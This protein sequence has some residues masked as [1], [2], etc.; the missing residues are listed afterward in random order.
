MLRQWQQRLADGPG[1]R[2]PRHQGAPRRATRTCCTASGTVERRGCVNPPS[3]A[4]TSGRDLSNSTAQRLERLYRLSAG[5][6]LLQTMYS[7]RAGVDGLW[8]SGVLMVTETVQES[9]GASEQGPKQVC[10]VAWTSAQADARGEMR[11][12]PE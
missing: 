3:G 2:L 1:S 5:Q 9:E 7:D 10:F 4:S 6:T 12:P 8:G 11:P